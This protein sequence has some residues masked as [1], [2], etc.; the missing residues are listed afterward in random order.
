ML[1]HHQGRIIINFG[2]TPLVGSESYP[3]PKNLPVLTPLQRE[4]LDAVEAIGR[5]TQ[6]EMCTRPG[7]IHFINNLAILHRREGFLD[8]VDASKKRHLVRMRLR[9]EELGWSIPSELCEE[10]DLTFAKGKATMWHLHPM[11][12]AFFPLRTQAN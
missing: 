1:F 10:W 3:R 8:G 6:L 4:A 7:D 2:R 5:A 12:E 11:P 9:D